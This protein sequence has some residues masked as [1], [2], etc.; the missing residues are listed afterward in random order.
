MN[1]GNNCRENPPQ[2]KLMTAKFQ[3]DNR[4]RK[5]SWPY[6]LLRHLSTCK[7]IVSR[8]EQCIDFYNRMWQVEGQHLHAN[9]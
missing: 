6:L 1:D 4:R 2:K 8:T 7:F 3:R 5:R 9:T